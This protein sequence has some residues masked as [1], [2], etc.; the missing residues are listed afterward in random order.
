MAAI[1]LAGCDRALPPK[2]QPQIGRYQVVIGDGPYEPSL[3][4]LDTVTG[5]MRLCK[6]ASPKAPQDLT[7]GK[8]VS[9]KP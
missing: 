2:P 3:F 1:T 4:V 7:C 9:A 5:M 8:P 6:K